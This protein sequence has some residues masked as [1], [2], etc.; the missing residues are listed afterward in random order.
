MLDNFEMAN[1]KPRTTPYEQKL[2]CIS[3][4]LVD[5]KGYREIVGSLI[6]AMTCTI[7]DISW[8]VS[9]L[10]QKL[11]NPKMEHLI[12]AKHV[13]RYLKGTIDYDLCFKKHDNELNLIAYC[14]SDWA[15]SVEDRR[16]TT[17][18]CFSLS[19]DGPSSYIMEI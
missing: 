4:E 16:S 13:L 19:E 15:C 6:Y 5:M 14:D 17:G 11:S 3:N 7:P 10:S 8:I 18:Y 1:C 12:A 2:E 9:K